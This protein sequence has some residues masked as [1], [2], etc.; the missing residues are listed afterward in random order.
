[1]VEMIKTETF[2]N[3]IELAFSWI[4]NVDTSIGITCSEQSQ[5]CD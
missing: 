4:V 5:R 2:I 1:M 3:P